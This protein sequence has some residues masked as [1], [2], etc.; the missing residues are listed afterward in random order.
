M[1]TVPLP[2]ARQELVHDRVME[3]V[4]RVLEAGRDLTFAHVARE[5]G[6]PERTLYRHFPSRDALLTAVFAW[7]NRKVGFEG[8]L[9]ETA[10]EASDLVRRVF[11][12]FDGI[13][14]VVRELLASE[15]GR[16]ARLAD[17]TARQRA[18]TALIRAEV[19]GLDAK[20]TRRLASVVQLLTTAATWQSLREYWD[21]E[22]DDAGAAAALGIELV[23]E[24]AR[25]RAG[26]GRRAGPVAA[27]HSRRRD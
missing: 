2:Q 21:M 24:A 18:Y 7:A 17:R 5:A 14:P 19:P 20:D 10:A 3:G 27:T 9:P 8:R 25:A 23:L 4:R 1:S 15:D 16:S 13:A 12:G 26:R 6:V 11:A 22:G